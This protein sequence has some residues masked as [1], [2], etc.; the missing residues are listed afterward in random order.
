M[1]CISDP[2]K[3]ETDFISEVKFET[4]YNSSGSLFEAAARSMAVERAGILSK[5]PNKALEPTPTAVTDPAD[6]GSAPAA[7]VAH[8]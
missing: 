5:L 4:D 2:R 3:D 8:L 1:H 6:A 7:V